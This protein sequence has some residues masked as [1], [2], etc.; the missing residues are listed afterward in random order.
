MARKN[1]LECLSTLKK[2]AHE[3]N[4]RIKRQLQKNLKNCDYFAISEICLNILKGNIPLKKF[5][6]EKLR[7]YK[8]KIRQLAKKDLPLYKRKEITN[9]KGGFLSALLVPAIIS[10]IERIFK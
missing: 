3:K 9:Q 8:E 4:P 1:I 5:R 6:R 10:L 7:K 2:L